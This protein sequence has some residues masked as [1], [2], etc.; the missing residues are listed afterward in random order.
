MTWPVCAMSDSIRL[1]GAEGRYAGEAHSARECLGFG[2]GQSPAGEV[3]GTRTQDPGNNRRETTVSPSETTPYGYLVH[4]Y[5]LSGRPSPLGGF[6]SGCSGA[7]TRY[8]ENRTTGVYQDYGPIGRFDRRSTESV[9]NV[10][11]RLESVV[12]RDGERRSDC[13]ESFLVVTAVTDHHLGSD[14][15][16]ITKFVEAAIRR[17]P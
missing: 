1:L 13:L 9:G 16:C 11:C 15:P 10:D 2:G 7:R 5:R 6:I 14:E 3:A 12:E 4:E 8:F 17:G